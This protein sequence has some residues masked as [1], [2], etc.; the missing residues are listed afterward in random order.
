[1][2]ITFHHPQTGTAN[3]LIDF[4]PW[5]PVHYPE[6]KGIY[7]NGLRLLINGTLKF[8]PI[9]VGIAFKD[10]LRSR[11]YN[12]HY[13]KYKTC[14]KGV[15]KGNKDIW[16]FNSVTSLSDLYDIYAEMYYYDS[17]N[18]YRHGVI[19]TSQG[20][21]RA[22]LSLK[23]L[24]FYQNRNYFV[25]KAGGAYHNLDKAERELTHCDAITEGFD[26]DNRIQDIKAVYAKDFYYVFC[27][28]ED[29][30]PQLEERENK[31]LFASYTNLSA[32]L[33]RIERAVKRALNVVGIHTTAK[34]E[35][36]F[37][38]MDIDLK[39]IQNELVNLGGHPYNSA[40][41]YS[42][43]IIPIRK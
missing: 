37:L 23:Y 31:D 19:R 36:E 11:L 18:N 24:L 29:I 38:D 28:I 21:L 3:P 25:M 15:G 17:I 14:G 16:D 27:P 20:Y 10:S 32:Q 35:G 4:E 33:E 5:N 40:G 8:V 12:Y 2:K 43:L 41:N 39:N 7:I 42:N 1:M 30:L 6:T 22:L 34:A 26:I 9:Y 13:K